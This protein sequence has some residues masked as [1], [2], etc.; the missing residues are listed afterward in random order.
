MLLLTVKNQVFE[1]HNCIFEENSWEKTL[2]LAGGAELDDVV[3]GIG[4]AAEAGFQGYHRKWHAEAVEDE[5]AFAFFD[6][7]DRGDF[8][9]ESEYIIPNFNNVFLLR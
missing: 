3:D 1:Q 7:D 6:A 8:A 4:P 2:F 5:H 9:Q